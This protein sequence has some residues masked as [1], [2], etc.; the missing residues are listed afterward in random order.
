MYC[1]YNG[2]YG[3]HD[4]S[5]VA[6]LEATIEMQKTAYAKYI[7]TIVGDFTVLGIEYDWGMH[8][9]RWHLKCNLG[10]E[11]SYKYC[12]NDWRRGKG[13]SRQ[14]KECRELEKV[15][16]QMSEQTQKTI[17]KRSKDYSNH[18]VIGTD[19]EGYHVV[20]YV[21]KNQFRVE[22]IQCGKKRLFKCVE[23]L[24]G[25]L[26]HCNHVQVNDYSDP[27]WIGVRNGHLTALEHHGKYFLAK[28][29]CGNVVN[30]RGV[31]M[32]RHHTATSCKEKDC[33]YSLTKEESKERRDKG[34]DYEHKAVE[35][36]R[37]HG[38]KVDETP[39][40]GDY[41]VDMIFYHDDYKIAVQC[42]RTIAPANVS[43][44]QQ[45]YAGGRYYDCN[46]FLV[47]SPS[48]FTVNAI[49][50]AAKL[51]VV[52]G[53]HQISFEDFENARESCA[54]LIET[55]PTL[56]CRR[57]YEE[58]QWEIDGVTKNAYE[59]CEEYNINRST[60]DSR[61]RRGMSLKDALS[62]PI[63]SRSTAVY[64]AFGER[65]TLT[66]LCE[67]YGMREQTVLYRMKYRGMSLEEALTTPKCTNGRKPVSELKA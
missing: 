11:E 52:L 17:A 15:L 33:P 66:L 59:W 35:F 24:R 20:E 36:F 18:P 42:K 46:A 49:K 39:D 56:K 26:T 58:S 60:V 28:C 16:K 6:G 14:C 37:S 8:M 5:D 57:K 29:D 62:T 51:G 40:I 9:Q 34:L 7:G 21:P 63:K 27:K 31:E 48:G 65:G 30:V 67:R 43:A 4:L 12:S 32:F 13:G 10:G 64:E 41:G 53:Q 55:L 22:C 47:M 45:V 50:L 23:V 25:N 1:L 38:F 2:E 19:V 44:V 54:A 3:E 61:L